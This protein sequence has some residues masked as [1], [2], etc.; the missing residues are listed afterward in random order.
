VFSGAAD[1][2]SPM[3]AMCLIDL[4]LGQAGPV[5]WGHNGQDLL[6]ILVDHRIALQQKPSVAL[7]YFH[8]IWRFA[9]PF[10]A[11]SLGGLAQ[12]SRNHRGDSALHHGIAFLE[13]VSAGLLMRP[14][15]F[16]SA[17]EEDPS[18]RLS[19]LHGQRVPQNAHFKRGR[20][21]DSGMSL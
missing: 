18:A 19:R 15:A 5:Q 16:R 6:F 14:V 7:R 12:G 17:P 9:P 4:M 20:D 21:L 10:H 3:P 1:R 13:G 11:R 2:R 8:S